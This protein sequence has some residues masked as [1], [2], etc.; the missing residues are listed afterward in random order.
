MCN[1]GLCDGAVV[2]VYYVFLAT[3]RPEPP[4]NIGLQLQGPV[5]DG[6]DQCLHPVSKPSWQE[7]SQGMQNLW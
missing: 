2:T 5:L 7:Q 1:Q 6:S 4:R 3:P